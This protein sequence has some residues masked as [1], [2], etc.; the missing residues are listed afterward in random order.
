M[1]MVEG[2]GV[3][4][5]GNMKE[6]QKLKHKALLF[7][8]QYQTNTPLASSMKLYNYA[9]LLYHYW[10]PKT[11]KRTCK[12]VCNLARHADHIQATFHPENPCSTE[13]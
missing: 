13:Q 5:E 12:M 4:R 11:K 6:I 8:T 2:G 7:T 10:C 1:T 3:G 9:I